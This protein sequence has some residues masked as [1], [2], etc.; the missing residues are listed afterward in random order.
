VSI[1]YHSFFWYPGKTL[2]Q[3]L[4]ETLGVLFDLGFRLEGA[5]KRRPTPADCVATYPAKPERPAL[6]AGPL[7]HLPT[8][9][10]AFA[11]VEEFRSKEGVAVQVHLSAKEF[12]FR[13]QVYGVTDHS[14]AQSAY[15]AMLFTFYERSGAF[16]GHSGAGERTVSDFIPGV[17]YEEGH[18]IAASKVIRGEI[19]LLD[20]LNFIPKGMYSKFARSIEELP[21]YDQRIRM[22]ALRDEALFLAFSG[23][24]TEGGGADW[25]RFAMDFGLNLDAR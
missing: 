3:A 23:F 17:S 14:A 7:A 21:D 10:W 5:E 8:D 12:E 2:K 1:S 16:Y 13:R 18:L 20:L 15:E 4:P 9:S 25:R 24:M 11:S 19:P 22:L 6:S